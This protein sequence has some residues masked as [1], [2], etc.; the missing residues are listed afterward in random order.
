ME[1]FDR[2]R[3]LRNSYS[4]S[5]FISIQFDKLILPNTFEYAIH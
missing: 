4:Q 5:K 2:W 3:G 1:K